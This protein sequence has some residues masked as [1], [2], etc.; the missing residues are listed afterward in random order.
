MSAARIVLGAAADGGLLAEARAS[1][2][3]AREKA[4][5]LVRHARECVL[6]RECIDGMDVWIAARA[7]LLIF[8]RELD[9][10][11]EIVAA[12]QQCTNAE[13]EAAFCAAIRA[14][15]DARKARR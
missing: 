10:P 2:F 8:T 1:A 13:A 15:V 14:V 3:V 11:D 5:A 9:D 6:W 7:T 12:R 4:I